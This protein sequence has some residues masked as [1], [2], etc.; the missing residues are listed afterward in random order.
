MKR[1]RA[2]LAGLLVVT[3]AAAGAV[4][5]AKPTV[6]A[7]YTPESKCSEAIVAEIGL[8]RSE[9]L[10]QAYALT[11]K[12]VMDALVHAREAG[13]NVSVILDRSYPY[14]QNSALYLSSL[15]SVP[16]F[17]DALHTVADNNIVIIDR[18]TVITGSMSFTAEAEERNA[19]NVV[20]VRSVTVADSY[21]GNW[22]AHREHAEAFVKPIEQQAQEAPKPASG[23]T[24]KKKAAK[25][26]KKKKRAS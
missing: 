13:A 3:L 1:D 12:P 10:V 20:I 15:K 16:T 26:R 8:A 7:C 17:I 21:A 19:E 25:A 24:E 5:C 11:S 23:K 4:S 2:R 9:V 6:E 18:E 14:A 22:N